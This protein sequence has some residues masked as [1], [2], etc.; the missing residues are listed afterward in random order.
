[1]VKVELCLV[2]TVRTV[3]MVAW[4]W[5]LVRGSLRIPVTFQSN[6]S[7]YNNGLQQIPVAVLCYRRGSVVE[8]FHFFP[9]TAPAS[10]DGGSGSSSSSSS[11]PSLVVHNLLLEKKF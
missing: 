11:S 10:Q 8:P 3:G 9:A 4:T 1:M 2:F 5:F 7:L 6:S